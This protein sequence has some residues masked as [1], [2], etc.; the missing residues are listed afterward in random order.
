PLGIAIGIGVTHQALAV[1]A[2]HTV[3]NLF[4]GQAAIV[5]QQLILLAVPGHCLRR[6]KWRAARLGADQ[7]VAGAGN[8]D[9][10]MSSGA[11]QKR[12]RLAVYQNTADAFGNPIPTGRGIFD[13]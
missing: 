8:D 1:T 5:V 12:D 3:K 10:A 7:N 2:L 9:S 4:G 11:A 6:S 13:P